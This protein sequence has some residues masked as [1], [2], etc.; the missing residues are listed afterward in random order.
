M[1]LKLFV[2]LRATPLRTLFDKF[3][4]FDAYTSLNGGV[5]VLIIIY[6]AKYCNV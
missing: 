4:R 2:C 3:N 5:H 1:H 6:I